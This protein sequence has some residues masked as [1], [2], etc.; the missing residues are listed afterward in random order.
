MVSGHIERGLEVAKELLAE[1]GLSLPNTPHAALISVVLHRIRLAVRGLNWQERRAGQLTREQINLV[2]ALR[3]VGQG[4]ALVDNIRGADFNARFLLRALELGD[5]GRI[6]QALGTEATYRGSQGPKELERA[7]ALARTVQEISEQKDQPYYR[8][9]AS[10]VSGALDY[11]EGRFARAEQRLSNAIQ[12]Y[13][14]ETT[15]TTWELSSAIQFRIF[16]LRHMGAYNTLESEYERELREA[17]R[18][19]DR[20]VQTSLRRYCNFLW[21]AKDDVDG[22]A[23]N[24]EIAPW[25]PPEGRFHL[26]HWYELDARLDLE[27]YRGGLNDSPEGVLA[28]FHPLENSLLMRVQTVRAIA[29]WSKGRA[30][31]SC[32]DRGSARQRLRMAERTAR[33]LRKGGTTYTDVWSALLLAAVHAGRGELEQARTELTSAASVAD[34]SS[35]K[36]MAASA[37]YRLGQLTGGNEGAALTRAANELLREESIVAPE[38]F[39][40]VL[41][42][43]FSGEG[44]IKLLTAG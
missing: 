31:L 39:L 6:A 18:R 24:L 14:A 33:K 23:K 4:L 30:L 11:F 27:M 13:R 3:A 17:E 35:M 36:L 34:E 2:E 22:A 29:M 28:R 20:H 38:R 42:P 19:G 12:L 9:W 41:A 16:S 26:Q 10:S 40:R 37:R 44:G 1:L 25:I 15:G 7:R 43:G 5:R 32:N 21:L 8:A